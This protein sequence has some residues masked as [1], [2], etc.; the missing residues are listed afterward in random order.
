MIRLT[1]RLE[2]LC[3]SDEHQWRLDGSRLV[4][5]VGKGGRRQEIAFAMDGK[6]YVFTSVIL[7]AARVTKNAKQWREL[8]RLVWQR[9]AG[10]E[11]VTF[12]FDRHHRLVGQIRHP[13]DH[14]DA[15]ELEAYVTTLAW[16]CDRFEY[17]LSGADTF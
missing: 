14:L 7:G 4:V 15:V 17:L 8:A 9:N 13:A 16:E 2:E 5:P 3:A 6:H 1:K 11:L 10:H 12:A